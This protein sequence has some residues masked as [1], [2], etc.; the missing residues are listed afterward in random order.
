MNDHLQYRQLEWGGYVVKDLNAMQRAIKDHFGGCP[1]PDIMYPQYYPVIAWFDW[2]QLKSVE[3]SN[4]VLEFHRELAQLNVKFF[5][6]NFRLPVNEVVTPTAMPDVLQTFVGLAHMRRR[7]GWTMRKLYDQFHKVESKDKHTRFFISLHVDA[8]DW[9]RF[10]PGVKE[11]RTVQA[12]FHELDI[13]GATS[14]GIQCWFG[15]GLATYV[16]G[17]Q[18]VFPWEAIHCIGAIRT[19]GKAARFYPH[20]QMETPPLLD[21]I[22]SICE[23]LQFVELEFEDSPKEDT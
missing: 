2:H 15:R 23:M 9:E 19:T 14:N 10:P 7:V 3:V 5:Q 22:Q 8:I 17:N 6:Y 21:S 4:Y 11:D 16:H 20:L 1:P 13:V 12:W 18:V